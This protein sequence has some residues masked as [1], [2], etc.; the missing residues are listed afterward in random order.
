M[1]TKLFAATAAGGALLLSTFAL[2]G[3]A[4]A[5]GQDHRKH[6]TRDNV[7]HAQLNPL[8][9]RDASGKARVKVMGKKLQV[10]YTAK[11]LAPNLPHAAHI[12]YGEQ[13]AHECPTFAADVNRD[14]R[15]NTAEG[16]PSY[17]PIAVSLTTRGDTSPASALAVDRFSSAPGGRIDY[18]RQIKVD[19]DLARAIRRGEGVLVVHG[20]DYNH[21]GQ[22]DFA[23]AGKSE[24]NAALPA[25]A[26]DPA[27]CGVLR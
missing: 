18:K 11:H 3:T 13:A 9:D 25:E 7:V 10:S 22:Y 6:N 2:G 16:L 14:G 19:K 23:G 8:N 27:L 20:V 17:G 21:N 5:S 15:V 24:L 4:A 1:K 26:T 12:H